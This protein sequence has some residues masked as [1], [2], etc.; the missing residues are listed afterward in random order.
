MTP[1]V[2]NLLIYMAK[3]PFSKVEKIMTT[4]FTTGGPRPTEAPGQTKAP[5]GGQVP[6][7]VL[8]GAEP[9]DALRVVKQ[10]RRCV[11]LV[12]PFMAE[13]YTKA[14]MAKRYADRCTK[15]SVNKQEAPLV[16]H[17]FYYD[18]LNVKNPIERDI[19]LQSQLSWIKHAELVAVYVDLGITPGMRVAINNAILL[20][21]RIEYRTIG[22]YA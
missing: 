16:S 10:P 17:S 21:K 2:A 13:D 14:N 3:I 22:N 12:S 7:S 11:V 5:L 9:D 20:S 1:V 18:V 8:Q 15:D 19:G 4:R 6:Q